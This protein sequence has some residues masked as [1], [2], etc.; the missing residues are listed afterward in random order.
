MFS[1]IS[2]HSLFSFSPSLFSSFGQCGSPSLRSPK[3]RAT[4]SSKA[5]Q[6]CSSRCR[7]INRAPLKGSGCRYRDRVGDPP[8]GHENRHCSHAGNHR[9]S[10]VQ[11]KE[12]QDQKKQDRSKDETNLL[13]ETPLGHLLLFMH[14]CLPPLGN[15]CRIP[16]MDRKPRS[17]DSDSIFIPATLKR[18]RSRRAAN[19]GPLHYR[20]WA[21]LK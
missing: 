7:A 6:L 18:R 11:I 5:L 19:R 12:Q 20:I 14:S 3:I 9:F 10:R 16:K 13:T 17:S 21:N 8:G 4:S 2:P 1:Q 15:A